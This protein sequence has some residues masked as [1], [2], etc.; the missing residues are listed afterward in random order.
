MYVELLHRIQR[1]ETLSQ[2]DFRVMRDLES[3]FSETIHGPDP[4]AVTFT[5][6]LKVLEYLQATGYKISKS[7]LYRHVQQGLLKRSST[8]Y[9]KT[10]IDR[11]A[12][13]NLTRVNASGIENDPAKERLEKFQHDKLEASARIAQEQLRLL[14]RRNADLDKE[15]DARIG[16]E[17]VKREHFFK[18]YLLNYFISEAPALIDTTHGDP[19]YVPEFIELMRRGINAA[20]GN[21]TRYKGLN[22]YCSPTGEV[23]LP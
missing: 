14:E 15:I 18:T 3:E 13:A 20:L 16:Q 11:Y 23:L 10:E 22:V 17:L 6:L 21:L 2:S 1:K 9:A 19:Q 8:G 4:G 7:P 5:S 12:A